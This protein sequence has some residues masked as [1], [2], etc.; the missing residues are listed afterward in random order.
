MAASKLPV[1]PLEKL[2]HTVGTPLATARS[3]ASRYTG[4]GTWE[5]VGSSPLRMAW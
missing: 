2:R 3:K 1:S 5:V 4:M